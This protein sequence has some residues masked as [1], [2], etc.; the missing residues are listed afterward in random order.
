MKRF[1]ALFLL[2]VLALTPIIITPKVHAVTPSL[3]TLCNGDPNDPSHIPPA[4]PNKESE[5][6]Q[7][8]QAINE[9]PITGPHGVLTKATNLLAFIVGIVSVF[10]IIIGGIKMITSSGDPSGVT[11]ARN[12]IL[13]ALIAIGIVLV[14]RTAVQ[15]ILSKINT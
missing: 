3:D 9:D 12:T 6:C 1:V 8:S 7:K 11:S 14:A 2:L 10:V 15:F 13:Y 5:T 4:D